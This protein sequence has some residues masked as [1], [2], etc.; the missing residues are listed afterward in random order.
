MNEFNVKIMDIHQV[1][2]DNI[3]QSRSAKMCA[4]VNFLS[5]DFAQF[6]IENNTQNKKVIS[7]RVNRHIMNKYV[8]KWKE[9]RQ[10]NAKFE[11]MNGNWLQGVYYPFRGMNL[12]TM[13]VP[14]NYILPML[15]C[16]DIFSYLKK[17][18]V[19]RTYL[20]IKSFAYLRAV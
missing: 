1:L 17:I 9:A 2:R 12:S 20:K 15:S 5:N 11:R 7:D 8:S 19:P 14:G 18:L 13:I 3:R 16:R 4:V 6:N 10:E